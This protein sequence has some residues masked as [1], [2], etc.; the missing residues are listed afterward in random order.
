MQQG[1]GLESTENHSYS[2]PWPWPWPHLWDASKLR[3]RPVEVLRAAMGKTRA[4][5]GQVP[6]Q[7]GGTGAGWLGRLGTETTQSK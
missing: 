4:C 7:W 6:H 3:V 5:W 2:W 1:L